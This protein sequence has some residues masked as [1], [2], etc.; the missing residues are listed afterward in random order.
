MDKPMPRVTMI[1]GRLEI[2]SKVGTCLVWVTPSEFGPHIMVGLNHRPIPMQPDTY[3][4]GEP[5]VSYK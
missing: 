1:S 4:R 3:D 5:A 2:Q